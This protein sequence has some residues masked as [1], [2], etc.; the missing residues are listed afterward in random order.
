MD[1]VQIIATTIA[2]LV[3][4][5]GITLFV[6]AIMTIVATIRLGAPDP[7]RGN[8]KG[9]RT[10]TMLRE[11]VGHTKMVKWQTVGIAHWFVAWGFILLVATLANALGQLFD[12][13]FALPIIGHWWPYELVTEF[14]SVATIV[15]IGV[16]IVIRQLNH[17]RNPERKSRFAGSNF[18]Q[19]YYVEFTIVAV[20]I[21]ILLIR[22]YE[23][24]LAGKDSAWSIHYAFTYPLA[25]LFSGASHGGLENAIV[26]TAAIKIVVS[27]A[28]MIVLGLNP[29]MG[30]AWHRFSAFF[31]IFFKRN[32]DGAV[33]LGA[34][35]PMVSDGKP[36]DF[37]EADPEKDVFGV[38]QVEHFSWKGMLDFTTCTECG[39]CQS[40]CPAWNTGKPLSPKLLITA[41][42]DHA[43]AKA[44][45]LQAG[46][47][48]DMAGD[49]KGSE[50]QLAG[51]SAVALA[52]AERPL[53]GDLDSLGVID[54]DILWSCTTCG[55]C[56]E[57]CPV[58]IEHVDHIVDMRR[59]QVMIESS[60]PSEAGTML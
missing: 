16:L 27:F 3:T 56:V 8:D 6:R 7:T 52:E 44:P 11:F 26:I 35:R 25:Q 13:E 30:V 58:D 17:P 41:L 49:E 28:W 51:V 10:R 45:Y 47:G 22:G 9:T 42:R 57:Q 24:V 15:A 53:I 55:A 50:E 54:P 29:T 14:L 2:L 12:P 5:V 18:W 21:C 38:S 1:A 48:K 20:P 32:A 59:Y 34:L 43:Y 37:E 4:V 60:F 23:A 46:G 19:A 36:L 40:Q 33:S 39:R 31:N